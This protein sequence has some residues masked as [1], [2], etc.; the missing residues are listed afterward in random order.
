M[1]KISVV[2]PCY[3]VENYLGECLDSLLKQTYGNMEIICI[4]DA[5]T[6]KTAGILRMYGKLFK[7]KIKVVDF[8][9]N[10]GL[11]CARNYGVKIAQGDFIGFVDS[12]DIISPYMYQDLL[13]FLKEYQAEIAS[14][15]LSRFEKK[16]TILELLNKENQH[17]NISIHNFRENP[18]ELFFTPAACWNRLYKRELFNDKPFLE[19]KIFE[20]NAFTYPTLLKSQKHIQVEHLYYFY[21]SRPNSITHTINFRNEK[22]LDCF[23]ICKELLSSTEKEFQEVI[24]AIIK[25]ILLNISGCLYGSLNFK[26]E[27]SPL[28]D[29]LFV[30]W[31]LLAE[32]IFPGFSQRNNFYY[33][34]LYQK[35][36]GIV[37]EILAKEQVN[38]S[39]EITKERYFSYVKE[40][41]R[42]LQ[43]DNLS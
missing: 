19:H 40:Y 28:E 31:V 20:D 15:K 23:D 6:D 30:H 42:S 1:E 24:N 5:S 10:Q 16:G 13:F 34:K 11:S 36:T 3:N 32:S 38:L 43:K 22:I 29:R 39:S 9:E 12:D 25:K 26:N 18:N 35:I 7:N 17:H 14:G 27:L 2:V 33:S 41:T 4:N 21:R 8:K 37:Q